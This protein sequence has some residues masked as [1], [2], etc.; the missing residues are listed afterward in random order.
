[1]FGDQC[2]ITCPWSVFHSMIRSNISVPTYERQSVYFHN[3]LTRSFLYPGHFSHQILRMIMSCHFQSSPVIFSHFY[4]SL[5]LFRIQK[6]P[7][8]EKICK[9]CKW[10]MSLNIHPKIPKYHYLHFTCYEYAHH[11]NPQISMGDYSVILL[12]MLFACKRW[13]DVYSFEN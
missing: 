13:A 12:T 4:Q 10:M 3:N 8:W 2:L 9:Y 7:C 6:Y 5:C 11:T 1:M